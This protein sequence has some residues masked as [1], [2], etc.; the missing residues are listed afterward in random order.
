[1]RLWV[2]FPELITNFGTEFSEI[3]D[4]LFVQC[5]SEILGFGSAF[6]EFCL[7][8]RAQP[9]SVRRSDSPGTFRS[10]FCW[11]LQLGEQCDYLK[12]G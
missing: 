5:S 3:R 9:V 2:S 1:M 8:K 6:G 12:T 7:L 4:H 11:A 10:R